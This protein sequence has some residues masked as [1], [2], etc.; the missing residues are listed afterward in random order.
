MKH[1]KIPKFEGD[2]KLWGLKLANGHRRPHAGN[3]VQTITP[4]KPAPAV[5]DEWS[6]EADVV[7]DEASSQKEPFSDIVFSFFSSA[8]QQYVVCPREQC[9][10]PDPGNHYEV[11]T[12]NTTSSPP[13]VPSSPPPTEQEDVDVIQAPPRLHRSEL[14]FYVSATSLKDPDEAHN[15]ELPLSRSSSVYIT[16]NRSLN[17]L[18]KDN[19]G[20]KYQNS[21]SLDNLS[22][23]C[24]VSLKNAESKRSISS[25]PEFDTKAKKRKDFL[26]S[27]FAFPKLA[28]A[29][30]PKSSIK[31]EYSNYF[32]SDRALRLKNRLS[33]FYTAHKGFKGKKRFSKAWYG[34]KEWFDVER[35]KL[36]KVIHK[37][38]PKKPTQREDYPDSEFSDYEDVDVHVSLDSFGKE[39]DYA[40]GSV[41]SGYSD[42]SKSPDRKGTR[43][44]SV[45]NSVFKLGKETRVLHINDDAPNGT[46]RQS[47]SQPSVLLISEPVLVK[48]NCENVDGT[49]ESDSGACDEIDKGKL[50]GSPSPDRSSAR[51]ETAEPVPDAPVQQYQNVSVPIFNSFCNNCSSVKTR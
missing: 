40:N 3:G 12:A 37:Q 5:V 27:T 50:V 32:D 45:C 16:K 48:I 47:R 24:N 1:F 44:R 51:S 42:K 11:M 15:Y 18:H 35:S 10:S 6:A 20:P 2:Y 19:D 17:D 41:L 7:H 9:E 23:V 49:V 21:A 22:Q 13:P 28:A 14:T 39:D 29:I 43:S 26:H 30:T 36:D 4:T 33:A 25:L 8:E 31:S 38:S 46:L 34:F